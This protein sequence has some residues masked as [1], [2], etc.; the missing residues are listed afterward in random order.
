MPES[1]KEFIC[2]ELTPE[3]GSFDASNMARGLPGVPAR[4]TW[5]GVEYCVA[6]VI[7]QWKTSS[8]CRNGAD[9]M[10]LRRHW[11]QVLTEPAATMTIYCDRQARNRKHPKSRWYVYSAALGEQGNPPQR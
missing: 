3:A 2:E 6:G 8:P 9:E 11:F 1:H 7:K 4:F 10:Y 5:R